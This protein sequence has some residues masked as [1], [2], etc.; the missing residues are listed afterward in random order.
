MHQQAAQDVDRHPMLILWLAFQRPRQHLLVRCEPGHLD[1]VAA[2]VKTFATPPVRLCRCPGRLELPTDRRGTLLL[3]DVAALD[4]R[5]QI[6]LYDWLGGD[7]GDLRVISMTTAS[8]APLV[9][10]GVFLEG[11]FHRLAAVQFDLTPTESAA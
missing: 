5:D 4:L 7:T 6:A 11:L 2:E 10:H 3:D 1:L 9:A 8:L